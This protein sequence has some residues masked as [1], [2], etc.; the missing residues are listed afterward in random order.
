MCNKPTALVTA[1]YRHLIYLLQDLQSVGPRSRDRQVRRC[2][3][4]FILTKSEGTK[5]FRQ[6]R[7]GNSSARKALRHREKTGTGV[8]ACRCATSAKP[9]RVR[10][11]RQGKQTEERHTKHRTLTVVSGSQ[12]VGG[13]HE[14]TTK[15]SA[16]AGSQA[17]GSGVDL[18]TSC[19][20]PP[21][22]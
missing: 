11:R 1:V 17:Q 9:C 16:H 5:C 2:K 3:K 7:S 12:S 4:M 21:C 20:E 6:G 8:S 13:G 18:P 14:R 15:P 10:K 22:E 19:S